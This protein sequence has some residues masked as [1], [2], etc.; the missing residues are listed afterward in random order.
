MLFYNLRY[1]SGITLS[2]EVSI[3][4]FGLNIRVDQTHTSIMNN[5]IV[6]VN[7]NTM[8]TSWTSVDTNDRFWIRFNGSVTAGQTVTAIGF[9]FVQ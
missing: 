2:G 7:N 9:L 6:T 8:Y 3:A 1:K 4:T 5:G